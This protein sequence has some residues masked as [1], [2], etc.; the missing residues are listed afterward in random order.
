MHMLQNK[1]IRYSIIAACS[2]SA[3]TGCIIQRGVLTRG[4]GDVSPSA[5]CPGDTITASYDFLQDLSCPTGLEGTCMS[6]S[7]TVA[8]TSSR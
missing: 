4:Y 6:F 1:W 2:V 3:A 7:P 8:I 5:Y